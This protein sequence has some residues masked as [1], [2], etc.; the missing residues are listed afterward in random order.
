[1]NPL[2]L[3]MLGANMGRQGVSVNKQGSQNSAVEGENSQDATDLAEELYPK[4][5]GRETRLQYFKSLMQK[6]DETA[7]PMKKQVPI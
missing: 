5:M 1:M 6:L 2:S 4:A 3:G 7:P